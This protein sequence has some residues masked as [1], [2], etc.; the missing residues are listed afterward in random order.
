[1]DFGIFSLHNLSMVLAFHFKTLTSLG[2]D[3]SIASPNDP[4]VVT[5]G[6][7][8]GRGYLLL[9]MAVLCLPS[10]NF[11][12]EFGAGIELSVLGIASLSVSVSAGIHIEV[13]TSYVAFFRGTLHCYGSMSVK[14]LITVGVG[15][16]AALDLIDFHIVHCLVELHVDIDSFFF[17]ISVTVPVE[18]TFG[19]QAP[20]PDGLFHLAGPLRELAAPPPPETQMFADQMSRADWTQYCDAFAWS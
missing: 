16:D 13:N 19:G 8:Y 18:F 17:S 10:L 3:F 20:P 12:I 9:R 5:V 11:A 2:I 7:F 14:G 4:C 1:V 15:F 6:P